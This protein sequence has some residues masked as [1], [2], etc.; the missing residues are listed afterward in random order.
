M[1]GPG[2]GIIG[3]TPAPPSS[4][5][6]SGIAPLPVADPATVPGVDPVVPEAV[7]PDGEVPQEPDVADVPFVTTL[8]VDELVC[9]PL[10]PPPSKVVLEPA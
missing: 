4:V 2:T 3:L 10:T 8:D 6:P 7:P 9:V 1:V 5:A